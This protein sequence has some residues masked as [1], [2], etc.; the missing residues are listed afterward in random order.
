MDDLRRYDRIAD[1]RYDG[2]IKYLQSFHMFSVAEIEELIDLTEQRSLEKGQYFFEEGHKCEKVAFVAKGTFR[3]F[4]RND[5]GEEI[6]YCF[7]FQNNFLTAYSSFVTGECTV[8]NIQAIEEATLLSV[9]KADMDYLI[10]HNAN[11]LRYSKIIADRQY[12]K[13][14]NRIFIL[15]KEKARN[16]YD[17]LRNNNPE[18]LQKIP[19][20]YLAS[21]LGMTSRHLSRLRRELVI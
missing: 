4:Y 12:I 19:L 8:E 9:D 10:D 15:Q 16:K 18:Y 13:R 6:N 5:S 3:H 2:M 11:W 1:D 17:A 21:Y 14:E 20:H 7:T